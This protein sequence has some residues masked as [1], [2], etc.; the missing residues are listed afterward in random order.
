M[1]NGWPRDRVAGPPTHRK[2]IKMRHTHND[3]NGTVRGDSYMAGRDVNADH[4]THTEHNIPDPFDELFLGR[5]LGRLLLVVG[6]VIALAGFA[7]WMYLILDAGPLDDPSTNPFDAQI[8]GLSAPM[9]A[10]GSAAVGSVIS[11]IGL[12]MSRAARDRRREPAR[13]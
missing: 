5:G 3:M 13:R 11:K 10:F 12:G 8:L 2:E 7:G 4:S 9:V 1:T 6:T